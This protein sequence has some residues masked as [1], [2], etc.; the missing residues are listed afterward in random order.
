MSSKFVQKRDAG[1]KVGVLGLKGGTLGCIE[2]SDLPDE[3]R[4][5]RDDQGRLLFGAGNIALHAFDPEFLAQLG[6]GGLRLPWHLARKNI[7]SIDER[8][9]AVERPGVKFETFVF[10]ALAR[11]ERSITVEADRA[12]EFSPVKNAEGSD[13]PATTRAALLEMFHSWLR[14]AGLEPP[15]DGADLEVDPTF[16]ETSDEFSARLPHEPTRTGSGSLYQA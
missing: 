1:E 16:A 15:R 5:A 9:L 6:G 4:D 11:A 10:D 12:L 14:D 3:L 2:Y 8:G 7:R 13:S